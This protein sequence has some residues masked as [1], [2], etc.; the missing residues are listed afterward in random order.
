[1][2]ETTFN[3]GL[4]VSRMHGDKPKKRRGVKKRRGKTTS[5]VH[6]MIIDNGK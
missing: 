1:M 3:E 5:T 6:C 2:A 4:Q